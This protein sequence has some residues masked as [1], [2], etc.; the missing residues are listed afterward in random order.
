[1]DITIERIVE[2]LGPKHGSIKELAEHLG[3]SPNVITNWKNGS[4]KSY[5]KYLPELAEYFDV[6]VGYLLGN[7]KKPIPQEDELIKDEF[8]AFYSEVKQDLDDDDIADLKTFIR[9]KSEI[10]RK[11]TEKK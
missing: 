10:K 2:C 8:I 1:M 5:K 7:E 6:S 11:L 9:M 3:V 4:L